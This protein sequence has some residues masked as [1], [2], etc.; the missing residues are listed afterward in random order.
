MFSCIINAVKMGERDQEL[1]RL[2]E[3]LAGPK[4]ERELKAG[5]LE[6]MEFFLK[7]PERRGF[8]LQWFLEPQNTDAYLCF[9]ANESLNRLIGMGATFLEADLRRIKEATQGEE[10]A[11]KQ[12]ATGILKMMRYRLEKEETQRLRRL[13]FGEDVPWEK[14]IS[15]L[16]YAD[17]IASRRE[18]VDV[19]VEF[20]SGDECDD[21]MFMIGF[22]TYLE[23]NKEGGGAHITDTQIS[24]VGGALN[25]TG[26]AIRGRG[27]KI[28][29]VMARH[30]PGKVLEH[31][32]IPEDKKVKLL[33]EAERFTFD[34]PRSV[35]V[36]IDFMLDSDLCAVNERVG[37]AARGTFQVLLE[38][39]LFLTEHHVKRVVGA[40]VAD[41]SL[42]TLQ[43]AQ[44]ENAFW[45]FR[46]LVMNGIE[47]PRNY[48]GRI[49]KAAGEVWP[50]AKDEPRKEE[51]RLKKLYALKAA[52]LILAVWLM[53]LKEGKKAGWPFRPEDKALIS[54]DTSHEDKELRDAAIVVDALI[55]QI[56]D[57][58]SDVESA[59]M[60]DA[61]L[62][63]ARGGLDDIL[64]EYAKE[65][66]APPEGAVKETVE[67]L[68]VEAEREA[69]A[70]FSAG[71]GKK[72]GKGVEL[73]KVETIKRASKP[74]R[75]EGPECAIEMTPVVLYSG[76]LG[77]EAEEAVKD[78]PGLPPD[79]GDPLRKTVRVENGHQQKVVAMK[80]GPQ[81]GG[82]KE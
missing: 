61:A 22:G 17:Y 69:D 12:R 21:E 30:V 42:D 81:Q 4:A 51:W 27:G 76:D 39:G 64:C 40:M 60:R 31:P 66:E 28:Y 70:E 57:E 10:G 59:S 7:T 38:S 68:L 18:N 6:D 54:Y 46:Q 55:D 49:I 15:A 16:E 71:E 67:G 52:E 26:E 41:P 25:S 50:R 33:E 82:K 2:K 3:I 5:R 72:R 24:Y 45:M 36:L 79:A 48:Q 23:I 14:K 29:E 58:I 80:I 77:K 20:I 62:R 8:L 53:E 43:E 78:K 1:E 35:S 56:D 9:A 65:G 73:A 37:Q 75:E 63:R 47:I 19:L 13:L 44:R 34:M 11:A 74:P 32:G